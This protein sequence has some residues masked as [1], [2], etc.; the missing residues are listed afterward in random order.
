M[1]TTHDPAL[2]S[3]VDSANEPATEFPIQNLPFGRFR[4]DS[5]KSAGWRIGVAIGDQVLDLAARRADRHRRHERADGLAAGR[6]RRLRRSISQG[7]RTRRA[8][9]QARLRDS[10]VPWLD[11]ELGLPCDIGDYT[12]FYT[13]IHHATT[14]GKQFRPE[15][16]LLPNYKWVPI[17]YHGRASSICPSAPGTGHEFSVRSGRPRRPMRPSRASDRVGA[18]TTSWSSVPL[19][20]GP[21]RSAS[22]S[23][24]PRRKSASSGWRSS[25]TG[26]RATS[27]RGS[28]SRW[29]RSSPRTSRARSRHGS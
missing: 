23:R 8:P 12:D 11:V 19:S 13:S 17:G 9:E 7:L 26:P 4:S 14:V 18:S 22:R 3:W 16:P 2:K 10:L 29:V 5:D 28:T 1:T 6:A 27:S 15:N 21:T 24:S 20:R 25:T